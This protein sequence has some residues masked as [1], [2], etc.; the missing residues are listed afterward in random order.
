MFFCDTVYIGDWNPDVS[1]LTGL[2]PV[3][4]PIVHHRSSL[5]GHVARLL[6]DTPAH[7]AL[8]C[9]IDLSLGCLPDPELEAM[10]RPP[11]EQMA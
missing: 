9:H 1:S 10:S 8:Q 2:S 3:L 11:S 6:E 4:D 7:Q 5:F